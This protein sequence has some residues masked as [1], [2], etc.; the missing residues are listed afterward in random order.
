ML[1][2]AAMV[3]ACATPGASKKDGL[4]KSSVAGVGQANPSTAKK[5]STLARL[6]RGA[7]IGGVIGAVVGGVAGFVLGSAV[8]V[9]AGPLFGINGAV[10]GAVFGGVVGLIS[11][12]VSK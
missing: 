2:I 12:A 8:M 7:A 3:A 6:A 9:G 1:L 10:A 4:K 5:P 11:T